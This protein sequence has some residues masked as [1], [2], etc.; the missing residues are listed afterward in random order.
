MKNKLEAKQCMTID[1]LT[2]S[3][4]GDRGYVI[5]LMAI[6]AWEQLRELGDRDGWDAVEVRIRLIPTTPG[7]GQGEYDK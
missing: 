7:E 4:L 3:K 2:D 6:D 1:A 5:S